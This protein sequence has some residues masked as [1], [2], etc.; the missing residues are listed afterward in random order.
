MSKSTAP[1]VS[2]VIPTRNRAALVGRAVH[3]ALAQ[4]LA[5]IEVIVV[6]DGPDLGTTAALASIV[7]ERVR[8]IALDASVGG[9]SAGRR[10]VQVSLLR[11]D[12]QAH[13]APPGGR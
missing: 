1:T 12:L 11:G 6:I 3:S 9:S 13:R 10:E 7:D 2:V 8:M 4:T 5:N